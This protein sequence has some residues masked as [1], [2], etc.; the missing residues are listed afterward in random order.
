MDIPIDPLPEQELS[1]YGMMRADN[2]REREA[3]MAACQ[4]FEGL[5]IMKK[6]MGFYKKDE[7]DHDAAGKKI[8]TKTNKKAKNTKKAKKAN[9]KLVSVICQIAVIIIKF[10]MIS[11]TESRKRPV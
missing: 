10:K 7:I 1:A 6:Y 2:I 5:H 8:R 11:E 3:E 9:P 4:F